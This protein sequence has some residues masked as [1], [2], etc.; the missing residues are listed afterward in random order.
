MSHK[1]TTDNFRAARDRLIALRDNH[2]EA[3]A[4]FEWP[5][6]GDTFNWGIDW[7]DAIARGNSR[8][9]LLY[10]RRAWAVAERSHVEAVLTRVLGNLGNVYQQLHQPDSALFYSLR[11]LA[12]DLRFVHAF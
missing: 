4:G 7:F 2:V 12:L 1:P 8:P 10:L 11:G 9:A 6:V 3:V 5:D